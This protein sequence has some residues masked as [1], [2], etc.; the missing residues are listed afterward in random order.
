MQDA[1]VALVIT[2]PPYWDLKNY[3]TASQMGLGQSYDEYLQQVQRVGSECHA[4]CSRDGS[5]VGCRH[6]SPTAT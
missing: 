6:P 3:R 1:S 5:S 2:S 4:S